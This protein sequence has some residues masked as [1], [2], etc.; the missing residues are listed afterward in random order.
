MNEDVCKG[1]RTYIE[2]LLDKLSKL[3]F[4]SAFSQVRQNLT[5]RGHRKSHQLF[6]TFGQQEN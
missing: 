2:T 1:E 6:Q 4:P 5:V 3:M